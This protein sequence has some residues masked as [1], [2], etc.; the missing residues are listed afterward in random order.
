MGRAARV[1][2]RG[3]AVLLWTDKKGV[4]VARSDDRG[5]HWRTWTLAETRAPAFFPYLV[6]RD[7]GELAATWF[8]ASTNDAH[9]LQWQAA[10]VEGADAQPRVLFTTQLPLESR[11]PREGRG[12]TL[13]ND[14]GG[15]Y[16]ALAFLRDGTL[17]V[18]SPI[19]N[20]PENRVGF[21]WWRFAAR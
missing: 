3:T 2:F 8:T 21:T 1:G 9:D 18:V 12:D 5:A 19:Q 16:L 6:A 7:S 17:G 4:R 10:R 15:E 14:P 11:R 13:F 20:R